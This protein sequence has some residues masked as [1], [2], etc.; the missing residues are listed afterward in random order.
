MT[1]RLMPYCLLVM[2]FHSISSSGKDRSMI[3]MRVDGALRG[4]LLPAI[5]TAQPLDF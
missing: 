1:Q 4:R 5:D 2:A 3:Q